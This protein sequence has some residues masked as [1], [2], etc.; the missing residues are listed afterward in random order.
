M[1]AER[2]DHVHVEVRD[3]EAAADWYAR[4]LGLSRHDAL[5]RWAS[6]P[7]GPLMLAGA[8]G[9]P[10]LALF[11]RTPAARSRDTTV[12]FR[13][14]GADFL[15]FLRRLSEAPVERRDGGA[16]SPADLVDHEMAWSLYFRDPDHNPIEL[17]TYD[18]AFVAEAVRA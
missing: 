5:G 10:A 17:T 18:Y 3:R 11:A 12:A 2:I 16:L 9:A 1:R 13:V 14:S 6:D 7:K 15:V 8:D 4:T